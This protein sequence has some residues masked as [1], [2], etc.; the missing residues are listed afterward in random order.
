MTHAKGLHGF[1]KPLLFGTFFSWV[2]TFSVFGGDLPREELNGYFRSKLN[3][4]SHFQKLRRAQG[5]DTTTYDHYWDSVR[6][7]IALQDSADTMRACVFLDSILPHVYHPSANLDTTGRSEHL[8]VFCKG[9][10][11][12]ADTNSPVQVSDRSREF[13]VFPGVGL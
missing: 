13:S 2:L 6:I 5:Y 4:T 1:A 7:R 10:Q 8:G 9:R 3:A 11:N 12:A